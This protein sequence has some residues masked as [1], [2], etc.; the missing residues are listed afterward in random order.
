MIGDQFL[1]STSGG[2]V[3]LVRGDVTSDSRFHT[4]PSGGSWIL[5]WTEAGAIHSI[6]LRDYAGG[7]P[8]LEFNPLT[9]A[10]K[11]V[12]APPASTFT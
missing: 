8:V 9:R 12:D 6:F 5:Q 2:Q 7:V 10:I 1:S 4:S 3:A 11:L